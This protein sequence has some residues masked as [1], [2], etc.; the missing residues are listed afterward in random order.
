MNFSLARSAPKS[1]PIHAFPEPS[2][3]ELCMT[4]EVPPPSK[5][6]QHSGKMNFV[7]EKDKTIFFVDPSDIAGNFAATR[8]KFGS[9]SSNEFSDQ[10]EMISML[11]EVADNFSTYF[12]CDEMDIIEWN[13]FKRRVHTAMALFIRT[14]IGALI[15]EKGIEVESIKSVV[16]PTFRES[17]S[18]KSGASPVTHI[19]NARVFQPLI[20]LNSHRLKYNPVGGE[21]YLELN[22]WFPLGQYSKDLLAVKDMSQFR[23]NELHKSRYSCLINTVNMLGRI[24]WHINPL[25]VAKSE[26]CQHG[27]FVCPT[28]SK[29]H[30]FTMFDT[31]QSAHGPLREPSSYDVNYDE[32]NRRSMEC[33]YALKLSRALPK[34][35]AQ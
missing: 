11:D 15:N 21:R 2:E 20:R 28:R 1:A 34:E 5:Q 23:K 9:L 3:T 12:N 14:N 35:T 6:L 33:R 13:A 30:D 22:F 26:S 8:F 25:R 32:G 4:P 17:C 16:P 10:D 29:L 19:D 27:D 18:S 7:N 31:S 24:K